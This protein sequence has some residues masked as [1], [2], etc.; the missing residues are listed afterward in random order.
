MTSQSLMSHILQHRPA[1][2]SL[3]AHKPI[4]N[5]GH[6]RA[7]VQNYVR[8][9][10]PQAS[11]RTRLSSADVHENVTLPPDFS[12]AFKEIQSSQNGKFYFHAVFSATYVVIEILH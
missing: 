1:N 7:D 4:S 3:I 11:A 8:F 12:G 6:I 10:L 9:S 5:E 2:I